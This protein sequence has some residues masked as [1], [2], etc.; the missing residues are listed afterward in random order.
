MASIERTAYPRFKRN[1]LAKELDALY[2]PT[3]G[4]LSFASLLARKA[5]PRFGLLFAGYQAEI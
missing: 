2:T 4:E 3:D 1:L 5:Q